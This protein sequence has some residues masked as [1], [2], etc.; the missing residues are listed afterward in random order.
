MEKNQG[1]E[2]QGSR[3]KVPALLGHEAATG[4]SSFLR[5]FGQGR[6]CNVISAR[7][8]SALS[9]TLAPSPCQRL[10]LITSRT[11]GAPIK[12]RRSLSRRKASFSVSFTTAIHG[13]GNAPRAKKPSLKNSGCLSPQL[14]GYS[15]VFIPVDLLSTRLRAISPRPMF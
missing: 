10:D 1:R 7:S 9:Q 3:R 14:A 8:L 11:S 12:T 2:N 13:R 5:F 15:R 6:T 4:A